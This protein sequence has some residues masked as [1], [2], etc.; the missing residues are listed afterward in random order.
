[1][2]GIDTLSRR[3]RESAALAAR[4]HS[5]KW[6]GQQLG[7]AEGTVA[8]HL[9]GAMRKL[10][11]SRR[12]HLVAHQCVDRPTERVA[13]LLITAAEREVAACVARGWSNAAIAAARH[14]SARTVANQLSAIYRKLRVASR[15]ELVA[16][17]GRAAGA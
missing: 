5:N 12:A 7:I 8:S 2:R 13:E 4:G 16:L 17:L 10:G 1:M 3:E 14:V 15:Y 9:C 11:L 6:I